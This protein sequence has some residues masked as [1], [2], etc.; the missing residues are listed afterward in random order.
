MEN[1]LKKNLAS[2]TGAADIS[3]KIDKDGVSSV[4]VK[5]FNIESCPFSVAWSSHE[6]VMGFETGARFELD[7][8]EDDLATL[9][10]LIESV[11]LGRVREVRVGRTVAMSLELEDGRTV[12]DPPIED[13]NEMA[14]VRQ[15]LPYLT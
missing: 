12:S 2:I 5:P 4:F 14:T 3:W 7:A 8:G 15:Y 13:G 11:I 9:Y 6:T 10:T 1:A